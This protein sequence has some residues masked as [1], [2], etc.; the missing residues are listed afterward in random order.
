LLKVVNAGGALAT[1]LILS[2]PVNAD[3]DEKMSEYCKKVS[4]WDDGWDAGV[5]RTSR[6]SMKDHFVKY[7]CDNLARNK[8]LYSTCEI[9]QAFFQEQFRNEDQTEL[10]KE[11]EQARILGQYNDIVESAT[12]KAKEETKAYKQNFRN[13]MLEI[14]CQLKGPQ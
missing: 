11:Q 6:N 3:V 7:I 1:L 2:Q 10:I 8:L 12:R 13:S 9:K 5:W 4:N 14:A